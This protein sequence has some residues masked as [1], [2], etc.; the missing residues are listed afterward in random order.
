MARKIKDG[1]WEIRAPDDMHCHLRDTKVGDPEYSRLAMVLKYTA[2]QFARA[3]AMP[4]TNP[5]I[6]TVKMLD[7]YRARIK[8]MA[9]G[10]LCY[11]F[12]PLMVLYA[13][14]ATP[15][16]V[17]REAKQAG[18]VAVKFYPQGGTTGAADGVRSFGKVLYRT[19]EVMEEMGL[20]ALFHGADPRDRVDLLDR[21][22][23]FLPTFRRI[24]NRF[25]GL[26]MVFE[27]MST[28]DS[29]Q[30]VTEMRNGVYGTITPQHLLSTDN[31][32]RARGGLR[33]SMHCFPPLQRERDRLAL[34]KAAVSGNPK[35]FAGTDSAPHIGETKYCEC[36][37]MGCFTAP[38]AFELY[39]E[40]FED[41]AGEDWVDRLE[42]FTSEYGAKA[43]DLPLN[44]G[45]IILE[46]GSWNVPNVYPQG[47]VDI[48]AGIVPYRAGG[49][50]R[51]KAKLAR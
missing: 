38:I 34:V 16:S 44:E 28:R 49:S 11:G 48:R 9:Y 42:A 47:T 24:A 33:P 35:F 15:P 30:C 43:Y 25:P 45:R 29:V 6:T 23:R 2:A 13:T 22:R 19:Y 17:Y 10:E 20:L 14:E 21:E 36:G 27:H 51:F 37:A 3:I 50:V 31:D 39:A 5:P 7:A 46:R 40:A 12:E 26:K 41:G 18:C 4:N 32:F 8:L 1:V